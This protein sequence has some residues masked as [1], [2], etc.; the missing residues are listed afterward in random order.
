MATTNEFKTQLWPTAYEGAA[1]NYRLERNLGFN[2]DQDDLAAFELATLRRRSA[3]AVRNI[4]VAKTALRQY[5]TM[6]GPVAVLWKN[7]KGT[8]ATKMQKLWNRFAEAPTLDTYGNLDNLQ[9][10]WKV[11]MFKEGEAFTRMLIKK[12]DLGVVPLVLQPINANYLDPTYRDPSRN[13]KSGIEFKNT[14]PVAYHFNSRRN[15]TIAFMETRNLFER[16]RIPAEEVLHIFSREEA[17]QWRGIPELTASLLKLYSYDDLIDASAMKAI[18]AKAISWVIKNTNPSSGFVPGHISQ[19]MDTS[20]GEQIKVAQVAASGV[21]YLNPGEDAQFFE[22]EGIGNNLLSL[23]DTQLANIAMSVGLYP[24]MLTGDI[25]KLSFSS[26][27]Y[28]VNESRKAA[29]L[30]TQLYIIN[31]GLVPLCRRFQELA[32]LTY[33]SAESLVPSFQFPTY[34]TL[35]KLDDAKTD[36]LEVSQNLNTLQRVLQDR[37][38]TIEEVVEDKVLRESLGLEFATNLATSM[39]AQQSNV[40]PNSNSQN[41]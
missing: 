32:S 27:K 1:D 14:K 9:M 41:N 5:T 20:T 28:L 33:R 16:V 31:L 29:E 38:L 18:A 11:E 4:D 10:L 13:I 25:G 39:S 40:V 35:D 15:S 24:S 34:V 21:H 3:N 12:R 23:I 22:G 17:G 37:G 30:A 7:S 8:T 19:T 36:M 2:V 26:L 6:L